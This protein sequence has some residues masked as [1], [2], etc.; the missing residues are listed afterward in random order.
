MNKKPTTSKKPAPLGVGIIATK[1]KAAPTAEKE[2][3]QSADV[4]VGADGKEKTVAVTTR[5]DKLRYRK[6]VTLGL[7]NKEK[8]LMH[9]NQDIMVAA[10]DAYL[11]THAQ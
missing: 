8:G 11:E 3:P 9:T 7:D 4:S 2:V 6:L 10:L 1:G 5:L